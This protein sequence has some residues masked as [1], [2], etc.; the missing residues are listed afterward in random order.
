MKY[1]EL[2]EELRQKLEDTKF[3][4]VRFS[5]NVSD[6]DNKVDD[7]ILFDKDS[8]VDMDKMEGYVRVDSP[9]LW[10]DFVAEG[11]SDEEALKMAEEAVK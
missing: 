10:F 8:E 5:S 7:A 3:S 9:A 11:K 6:P 1:A 2:P 4:A